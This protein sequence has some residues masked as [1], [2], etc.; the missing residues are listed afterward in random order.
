MKAVRLKAAHLID[1]I[2][3]DI[4]RPLLQQLRRQGVCRGD[5]AENSGGRHYSDVQ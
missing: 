1:P 3:I 2:G 5:A 4:T